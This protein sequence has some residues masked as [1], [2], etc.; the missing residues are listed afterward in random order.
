MGKPR[1]DAV[2]FVAGS[3][4]RAIPAENNGPAAMSDTPAQPQKPDLRGALLRWLP[5]I[6]L[7]CASIGVVA[8]GVTRYVDFDRLVASRAWLHALVEEDRG[9]AIAVAILVYVASV[10]VSIPATFVL[11][12]FYGFLFGTVTGA[13]IAIASATTGAGIVF[14]IGRN[15][16]RDLI[17]KRAGSR[18]GRF[19]EGF[20]RDAFGYVAFLRLLP[21]FP[22]WM[23]NLAPAAFG[24]RPRTFL[25]ATFL[26]L[27]PGAFIYAATGAGIDDVVAAHE[28]AKHACLAARTGTDCDVAINFRQLLTP[29][30]ILAL[31]GL[32]G[33]ALLSIT[34]RKWL[35]RRGSLT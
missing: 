20:R 5:L 16:A 27:T 21:L 28:A 15:A 9:R 6:L 26:G 22:F 10:V 33:F 18:L 4:V 7:A 3:R 35:E 13:L 14:S 24:V 8:T 31:G 1:N 19:A 34:L 25:L 23:T 12:V 11:T 29:G 2:G 17:Q 32:A 30:M